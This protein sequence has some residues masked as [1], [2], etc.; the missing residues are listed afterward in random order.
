[1]T[2]FAAG[3]DRIDLSLID[4]N[5]GTSGN[6]AFSFIGAAAFSGV[7]GQLR[8]FGSGSSWTVEADVNGDGVAD[9]AIAVTTNAPL[10]V[11]EFVL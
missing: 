4:A 8:A 1:M 9:L 11:T 2:D 3:T 5:S 10:T 7:A 6:D